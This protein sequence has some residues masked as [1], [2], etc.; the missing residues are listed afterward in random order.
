MA[1]KDMD[2]IQ[3]IALRLLKVKNNT[4]TAQPSDVGLLIQYFRENKI[5]FIDLY[6]SRKTGSNG[7]FGTHEFRKA[8]D[9]EQKKHE[10]W[11][12]DFRQI[13]EE[14]RNL[15]IEHIFIKSTAQ[16]PYMSDNLDVLVRS[17]NFEKAGKLLCEQGYIE[18]L[19]VQEPH[20][21]LY[22][23]F[24]GAKHWA[25][26]H[27][28]ERVCWSVPYEDN[29]H[30]WKH[31]VASKEDDIVRYPCQEDAILIHTAHCFLEDH[32][33][34]ISDLLTIK[35]NVRSG[36]VDWEYIISTADRMHWLHALYTGFLILDYLYMK[37]FDEPLIPAKIVGEAK[38][39]VSRKAWIQRTLK[40]KIY[41]DEFCMPF[42]IPHLWTRVHSSL[43][44]LKDPSFGKKITR[45]RQLFEHL[46][47]GF[48]H[49]KLGV[50]SHPKMLVVF[51]GLDGSGK[52][53]HIESLIRAF[54]TCE[55]HPLYI[56]SRAGSSPVIRHLLKLLRLFKPKTDG[57]KNYSHEEKE[58]VFPR[59]RMTTWAWRVI[60]SID[61]VFYYFFRIT[62]P[63]IFGRVVIADRYV[64]DSMVDLEDVS[65]TMN[66]QRPAYKWLKSLTPSPD[67]HFYL[68]LSPDII[69]QRG[70][71]KDRDE[72]LKESRYY[73]AVI[74]SS[75]VTVIENSKPFDQV[76]ERIIHT[77]L[78]G[79]YA[80]YPKKYDGYR[81][82]SLKY[83]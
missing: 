29:E 12:R 67:I 17:E 69:V 8:Y 7:F 34:K 32:R 45:Y 68:D 61:L 16:F 81:M 65:Q 77:V 58:R 41:V 82:V 48:I 2:R 66:F 57:K 46:L 21:K 30:L 10:S 52:T 50:N 53:R 35:K 72:L 76:S 62:L 31:S 1:V 4:G 5:S 54:Q 56:W 73:K 24:S 55:I 43:R 49:L 20:K 42:R 38:N 11:K 36:E 83:K 9:D 71:S 79:F 15:G 47:D 80:K 19:N 63:L 18:L 26:V 25:P 13:R 40:K 37:L 64:Y 75:E 22:R 23:K 14:W 74:T 27:L 3:K 51:S 28:H 59:N 78:D 60:N 33:V 6:N 44:V 70:C 39:Y